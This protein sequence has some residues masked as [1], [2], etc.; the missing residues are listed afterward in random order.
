MRSPRDNP[1]RVDR[2]T[3]LPFVGGDVSAIADRL[4]ALGRGAIVGP[5]GVGKSTL[6][7][8]VGRMLNERGV[9]TI[10][11]GLSGSASS[12]ERAGAVNAVAA[13][14]PEAFVLFDGYEQL[15][16]PE[17]RRA[18]R[19]ARLLVTAHRPT[20]LPTLLTL[21]PTTATLDAVLSTLGVAPTAAAHA[22]FARH[23][24]DVRETLMTL[25]DAWGDGENP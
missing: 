4:L 10:T 23:R 19:H 13:A 18:R 8:D 3:A 1:F 16:W 7:H 12:A 17:R 25:Y 6:M 21:R 24:G 9:R 5:H 15:T 2:V 22:A 14:P 11:V 20:R